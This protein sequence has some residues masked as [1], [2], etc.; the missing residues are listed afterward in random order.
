MILPAIWLRRLERG[1]CGGGGGGGGETLAG[2]LDP[3]TR[4]EI[5][6]EFVETYDGHRTPPEH[7]LCQTAQR[8][9][10]PCRHRPDAP[11]WPGWSAFNSGCEAGM[12]ARLLETPTLV[13][14]PGSL[15]DAHAVD[16]SI[17]WDEVQSTAAQIALAALEWVG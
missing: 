2:R 3:I 15:A 8:R 6:F 4:D 13:W 10:A 1:V 5:E 17:V 14:G 7:P 16:E 11:A 9:L 12:R